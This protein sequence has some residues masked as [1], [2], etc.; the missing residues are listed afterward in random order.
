MSPPLNFSSLNDK[1]GF[2]SIDTKKE[3]QEAF[4]QIDEAY[5][6]KKVSLSHLDHTIFL[7]IAL[8]IPKIGSW[9]DEVNQDKKISIG[10]IQM[11]DLTLDILKNDAMDVL[12]IK[13]IN[14]NFKETLVK[15]NEPLTQ[16][17]KPQT[18]FKVVN[19][20]LKNGLKKMFKM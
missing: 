1:L 13:P 19:G 9:C 5:V 4:K 3:Y 6:N 12:N 18:S 10:K 16:F 11:I 17:E 8:E 2:L 20:V 15:E 14:P 7:A